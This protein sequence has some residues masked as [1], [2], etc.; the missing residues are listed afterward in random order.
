MSDRL[1]RLALW[2]LI[3]LSVV[4]GLVYF[5]TWLAEAP[6]PVARAERPNVTVHPK[7]Y[8]RAD[9]ADKMVIRLAR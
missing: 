1:T 4:K 3:G 7:S 6:V 9:K 8:A 2:G 5:V